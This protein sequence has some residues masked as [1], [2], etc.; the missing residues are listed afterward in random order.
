MRVNAGEDHSRLNPSRRFVWSDWFGVLFVSSLLDHSDGNTK[1]GQSC[2]KKERSGNAVKD[3]HDGSVKVVTGKTGFKAHKADPHCG[4]TEEQRKGCK[5]R[6]HVPPAG[7][8]E[9][10]DR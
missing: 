6:R 1:R 2:A 3:R 4:G 9:P 10:D 5:A 8:V 7:Q